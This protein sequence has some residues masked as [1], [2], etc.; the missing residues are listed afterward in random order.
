MLAADLNR[1]SSLPDRVTG[2]HKYIWALPLGESGKPASQPVAVL[3]VS[4]LLSP[5]WLLSGPQPRSR[6]LQGWLKRFNL[7]L[8]PKEN[9]EPTGTS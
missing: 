1:G 3:S 4:S 7:N 8:R 2:E 5:L 6:F 9:R